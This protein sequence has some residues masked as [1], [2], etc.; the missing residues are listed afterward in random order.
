[1]LL[2]ALSNQFPSP[3]RQVR[4]EV[5]ERVRRWVKSWSLHIFINYFCKRQRRIMDECAGNKFI[6]CEISSCRR[7]RTEGGI[8]TK[9]SR[10]EQIPSSWS[11][12]AN[13][14]HQRNIIVIPQF[15]FFS[16]FFFFSFFG[17]RTHKISFHAF[18]L[19]E[20]K[21]EWKFHTTRMWS[22]KFQTIL[23]LKYDFSS[24]S[25]SFAFFFKKK[26]HFQRCTMNNFRR[27]R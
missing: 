16:I 21:N 20:W 6:K 18:C 9:E 10:T 13:F 8:D 15:L 24:Y 23:K 3:N 27:R 11:S 5:S 22:M 25:L 12:E 17:S 26:S 2:Y 7:R 19:P 4:K 14:H 1:M